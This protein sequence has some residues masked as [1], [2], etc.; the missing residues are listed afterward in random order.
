[1]NNLNYYE[2]FKREVIYLWNDDAE[3]YVKSTPGRGYFAKLKGGKE[4]EIAADTDTV[5]MAIHGKREVTK[6]EYEKA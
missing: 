1:M 4:F 5:V 3:A 6:E 2:R